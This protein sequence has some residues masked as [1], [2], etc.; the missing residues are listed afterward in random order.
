MWLYSEMEIPTEVWTH[1]SL[2]VRPSAIEGDGLFAAEPIDAGVV[3]IRLGGHVV[4]TDELHRLFDEAAE[5]EYIDTFA[6]GDDAHIVLPPRTTA[7]F[8]NHSCDPT[9]WPVGAFELATRRSVDRGQELTV[10]YGTISDDRT[11]RLPCRCESALCRGVITGEDWRLRDLQERY[12]GH[13]P[14]GLQDRITGR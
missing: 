6:V 7:H 4:T 9:L 8:G 1:P 10:D 12:A 5:G 2:V 14:P 3:I 13:W 11:F